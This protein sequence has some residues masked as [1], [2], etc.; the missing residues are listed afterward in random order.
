MNRF[1]NEMYRQGVIS[2]LFL[3]YEGAFR[4]SPPLTIS[5]NEIDLACD[6][7]IKSFQNI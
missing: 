3:F 4:I 2:D 5:N 6:R 1:M 7:I